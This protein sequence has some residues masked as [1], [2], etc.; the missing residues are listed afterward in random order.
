[1]WIILSGLGARKWKTLFIPHTLKLAPI[2]CIVC[3]MRDI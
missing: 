2:R 1:M 3:C